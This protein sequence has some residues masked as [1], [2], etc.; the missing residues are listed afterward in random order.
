M[1]DEMETLPVA[2]EELSHGIPLILAI[3]NT[4]YGQQKRL[5]DEWPDH[6]AMEEWL[7][8]RGLIAADGTV[9]D[10]DYRRAIALREALRKGLRRSDDHGTTADA[11]ETI[12]HIARHALLKVHFSGFAQAQLAPESDGVDGVLARLLGAVYTAIYT[13]DSAHIKICQNHACSKAFYDGSRNHTA[14]WCSTRTCGNRMHARTY[15]QQK[16]ALTQ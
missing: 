10:G 4:R 14:V 3:L 5:H 15:R 7:R 11:L 6:A 1:L 12:N 8:E 9:M 16:K 13:G 2:T